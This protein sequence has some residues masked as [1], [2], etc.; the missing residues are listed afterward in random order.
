[1]QQKLTR[2]WGGSRFRRAWL[3]EARG[4]VSQ[5]PRSE[6]SAEALEAH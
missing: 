4:K 5:A 6:G 1:M 2:K 3:C